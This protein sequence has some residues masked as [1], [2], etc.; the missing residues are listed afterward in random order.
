M[1]CF[2]RGTSVLLAVLPLCAAAANCGHD[3]QPGPRFEETKL[4]PNN[5][6]Y[7][8]FSPAM[9]IMNNTSDPRHRAFGECRGQAVVS[10]GVQRW[11]GGCIWKT[12]DADVAWVFW[13]A[14]PGD[15]GTEKRDTLHGTAVWHGTGKM[16]FLNGKTG[17]WSGLAPG[18]SYFC[19]D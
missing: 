6:I 12:S 3:V 10:D 4:A 14:N 17:K 9:L 19:D 11:Q 18:G 15:T 1:N 8:Y 16:Q 2:I 5:S 13:A 7:T